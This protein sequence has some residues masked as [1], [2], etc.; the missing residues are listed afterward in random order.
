M[1]AYTVVGLWVED[2]PVVAA[3]LD[4]HVQT[5]DTYAGVFDRWAEHVTAATPTQAEATARAF[6]ARPRNY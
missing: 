6:F 1:N 5:V 4:G 3:V 2:E